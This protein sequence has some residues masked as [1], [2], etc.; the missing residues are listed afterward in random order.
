MAQT[1][2]QFPLATVVTGAPVTNLANALRMH[3]DVRVERWV[4]QG[5]FAGDNVVLEPEFRLKKFEGLTM[6][7]TCTIHT[8]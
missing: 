5:G 8:K 4:A 1:L 2:R 6:C 7:S 3:E